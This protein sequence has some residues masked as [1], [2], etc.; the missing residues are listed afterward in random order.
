MQWFKNLKVFRKISVIIIANVLFLAF[1]GGIS[2]YYLNQSKNNIENIYY[3]NLKAVQWI[4]EARAHN[5]AG[6][7]AML[8][9]VYTD[10]AAN[11][12]PYLDDVQNREKI[13]DELLGNAESTNLSDKEMEKFD[14]MNRALVEYRA[15]KER[16]LQLYTDNKVEESIRYYTGEATELLN[17]VNN[18]LDELAILNA[19]TAQEAQLNMSKSTQNAVV[20][21][22][23]LAVLAVA[24]SIAIGLYIAGIIKKPIHN[25]LDYMERAA[26]GD[27]Q[28]EVKAETKDEM[29]QL[30]N[31]FGTMVASMK[32]ILKEIN[33]NAVNLAANAEQISASSQEISAASE[34]QAS[35]TSNVSEMMNDMSGAVN[36][37]TQNVLQVTEEANKAVD[38]SN[39]GNEVIAETVAAM[40]NIRQK[41]SSLSNQSEKI[42]EIVE[43]IDDIAEQTNLLAVNAAIE[44]ARAGEAGKGFAVVADEVRKLAERSGI[45]TKE[46]SSLIRL[47][48]ENVGETV[49]AVKAGSQNTNEAGAS[50]GEISS[51]FQNAAVGINEIAAAS[52]ELAGQAAEVMNSVASIASVSEETAA[53]IQQTADAASNLAKMSEHLNTLSAKFK[54]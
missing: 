14:D 27:L 44:A 12:A 39:S 51:L 38:V 54:I 34:E 48:Q 53:T 16:T 20:L 37:V 26:A 46:I 41:I 28:F 24:V 13:V 8:N 15:A 33:D 43:V 49:E 18:L 19:D 47:I 2:Y 9:Y 10:E 22:I 50:F 23:V 29:G 42:G 40:E 1:I 35:S 32:S 21:I 45:A 31:A 6:L 4:N 17:T 36:S 25:M 5:R 52:E 11:K 30:A 3:N 7:A